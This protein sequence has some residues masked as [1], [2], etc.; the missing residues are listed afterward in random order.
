MEYTSKAT[1]KTIKA[2]SRV[3]IKVRDNFYTIEYTEEREV[4]YDSSVELSKERDLLFDDVNLVVDKQA[5]DI[6]KAFAKK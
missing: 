3:A 6:I 4:P 1:V 5:E 2:T